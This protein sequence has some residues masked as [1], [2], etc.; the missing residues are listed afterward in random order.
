MLFARSISV[1]KK[2][3][4]ISDSDDHLDIGSSNSAGIN[5]ENPHPDDRENNTDSVE[6]VDSAGNVRRSSRTRNPP[7]RFG[8]AYT[9]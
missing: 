3:K 1:V 5:R 9:R 4:Y 7:I 2:Y 6:S 8:K